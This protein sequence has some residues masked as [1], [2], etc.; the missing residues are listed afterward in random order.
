MKNKRELDMKMSQAVPM[1][2]YQHTRAVQADV[3]L[4]LFE[5]VLPELK[6]R[7][8]KITQIVEWS[9][10]CYLIHTNPGKARAMGIVGDKPE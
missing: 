3:D 7:R 2:S 10:K 5:A 6:R 9:L 8:V 1:P 4:A